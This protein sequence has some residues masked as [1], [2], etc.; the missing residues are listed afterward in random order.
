MNE[1]ELVKYGLK[2]DPD[3]QESTLIYDCENFKCN[4]L[5]LPIL[6]K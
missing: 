2:Y 5:I 1:L 3:F 6:I 4:P